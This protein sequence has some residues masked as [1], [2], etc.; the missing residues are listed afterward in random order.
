[1]KRESRYP[2]WDNKWNEKWR[3]V[4]ILLRELQR[5]EMQRRKKALAAMRVT[6][7]LSCDHQPKR[8]ESDDAYRY[9]LR[10][11]LEG[12]HHRDID[13]V[14]YSIEGMRLVIDEILRKDSRC[15]R[16]D[17]NAA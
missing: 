8:R 12:Y 3:R 16:Q 4:A 17:K 1:M 13:F 10:W 6:T 5:T 14:R 2:K 9:W 11:I 15:Q 7:G